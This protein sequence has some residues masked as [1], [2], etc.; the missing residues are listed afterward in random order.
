M[1]DIAKERRKIDA[2]LESA[3][4]R[5]DVR[6]CL[7]E[8]RLTE[9]CMIAL[10]DFYSEACPDE[11]LR[12]RCVEFAAQVVRRRRARVKAARA[13]APQPKACAI[14]AMR[15]SGCSMPIDMRMSEGVIPISRRA[16]S[17]RPE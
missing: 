15:S 1:C 5:N 11:C 14:S 6:D 3:V 12:K 13:A 10:D 7:D 4:E 9:F 17:V 16:S 2:I 8:S